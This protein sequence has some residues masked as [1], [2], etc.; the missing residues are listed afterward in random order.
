MIDLWNDT[1][2]AGTIEDVD[3]LV[4]YLLKINV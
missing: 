4:N 3:G 1:S 2:V